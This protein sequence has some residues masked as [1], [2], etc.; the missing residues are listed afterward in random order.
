[1]KYDVIIIGAGPGGI[2]SAYELLEQNKDL[3]IAVFEAG[4]PLEKRRCPIDGD[5]VKTYT[6]NNG[7]IT[8]GITNGMPILFKVGIKPTPSI[9]KKQKTIDI[10]EKKDS[11]LVI[12]G[13]H[14]PCIVQRAVPVIEAV[15]AIGILDLIL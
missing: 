7:G 13:R 6:N 3:K 2:F 10:A 8:G 14:D 12:E 5:K 11:E 1:M 4:A 9:A 15:T